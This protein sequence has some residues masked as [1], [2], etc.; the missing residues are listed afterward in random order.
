MIVASSSATCIS[1]YPIAGRMFVRCVYFSN[2]VRIE[3]TDSNG[4]Y[5]FN[6]PDVVYGAPYSV[7][8]VVPSGFVP[9]IPGQG[10]DP[11]GCERTVLR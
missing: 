10:S 4:L 9:T 8:V 6:D 2:V 1:P 3:I 7:Q 5:E 11:G